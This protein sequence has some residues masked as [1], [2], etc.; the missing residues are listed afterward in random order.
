MQVNGVSV[1][2]TEKSELE[3]LALWTA[4]EQ[5]RTHGLAHGLAHVHGLPSHLP[6]LVPGLPVCFDQQ[7][8]LLVDGDTTQL[9]APHGE[10]TAVANS[11][12][13]CEGR[14]AGGRHFEEEN[15][16]STAGVTNNAQG[17][18]SGVADARGASS[19]RPCGAAGTTDPDNELP[20]LAAALEPLVMHLQSPSRLLTEPGLQRGISLD[21]CTHTGSMRLGPRRDDLQQPFHHVLLQMLDTTQQLLRGPERHGVVLA[22]GLA[23]FNQISASTS[24][25]NYAPEVLEQVGVHKHREAILFSSLVGGGKLFG[26][27]AG[28]LLS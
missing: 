21:P 20:A 10:S 24:I 9:L 8:N 7:A 22:V 16:L 27:L 14:G 19:P 13:V 25:I 11:R 5:E 6:D 26:V 15:P 17:S 23:F 12:V 1:D 18:A 28:A 4:V 3:L 2:T